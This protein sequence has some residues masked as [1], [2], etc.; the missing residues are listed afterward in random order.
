MVITLESQADDIAIKR[1]LI[2]KNRDNNA[3]W[4][5]TLHGNAYTNSGEVG[6]NDTTPL[7]QNSLLGEFTSESRISSRS[8]L[9]LVFHVLLVTYVWNAVA[10]SDERR[11]TL[12]RKSPTHSKGVPGLLALNR[13]Q[14]GQ[15][16]N[17]NSAQVSPAFW[18]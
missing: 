16:N 7:N 17:S 9:G 15:A 10:F 4:L 3:D 1:Y 13:P 8:Y 5:L 18:P 2:Q 6:N 14:Q 11:H 12:S